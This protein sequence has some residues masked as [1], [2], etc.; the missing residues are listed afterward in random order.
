MPPKENLPFRPVFKKPKIFPRKAPTGLSVM[1]KLPGFGLI[2][3]W[4]TVNSAILSKGLS[5][6]MT[7]FL[8]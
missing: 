2:I 5:M 6:R 8:R 7:W 1:E 4:A 3:G